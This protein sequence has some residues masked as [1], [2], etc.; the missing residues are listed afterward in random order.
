MEWSCE[1]TTIL[2]WSSAGSVTNGTR[3]LF[4]FMTVAGDIT[5]PVDF[6]PAKSLPLLSLPLP[7]PP[8][9]TPY[10]RSYCL[11][12][13]YGSFKLQFNFVRRQIAFR[14][15]HSCQILSITVINNWLNLGWGWTVW[16]PCLGLW[17]NIW[18]RQLLWN[19]SNISYM[20]T[21]LMGRH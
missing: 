12:W 6:K 16:Q 20:V 1:L 11:F 9:P 5:W 19:N 7:H 2:N 18:H 13:Y 14:K 15:R 3:S 10:S 21:V 8:P 4:Q 17:E